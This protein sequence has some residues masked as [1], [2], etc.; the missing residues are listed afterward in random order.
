MTKS[1]VIATPNANLGNGF[2]THL[3]KHGYQV[4]EIATYVEML[5]E[6]LELLQEEGTKIDSIILTSD[7]AQKLKDKRLEYLTDVL[8]TIRKSQNV[9][10]IIYANEQEG[11]PFLGEVVRMGIYNIFVKKSHS[12]SIHISELIG[13]IENPLSFADA[14]HFL[15]VDTSIK[16]DKKTEKPPNK[17]EIIKEQTEVVPNDKERKEKQEKLLVNTIKHLSKLSQKEIRTQYRAFA[18]KA[19]VVT[20]MKGGIGKTDVSINLA[21]ALKEH[22]NVNRICVVDFDFPYGGIAAALN[23]TRS[24]D[25]GDWLLKETD[26]ITEVGVKSKVVQHANIDF[27]PMSLR[28]KDGLKFQELHA[29]LLID[30][31]KRYYDIVIIDTSGFS[32]PALVALERASEIILITSHDIVSISTCIAYKEDLINMYG[33]DYEKVSLFINQVP[34]NEDITKETI[35]SMFEDHEENS[36]PVIGFAPY[37]D[38][39][40]QYRN[41]GDFIYIEKPNHTFSKG[42][43][44]ILE[45]LEIIPTTSIKKRQSEN[46]ESRI[47]SLISKIK[48]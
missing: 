18:S 48:G 13:R 21:A 6:T 25:L 12:D 44:M 1:I 38:V 20:S 5:I 14:S 15:E 9:N 3:E 16:W 35:A 4:K 30:I 36:I 22:T 43:D 10:I 17:I 39:V 34:K 32:K 24:R 19:I 33:I 7:I 41:R 42:I 31:L 29:E 11:H 27:I 23:L 2:K 28:L 45:S 47:S 26:K 46:K 40:R 37:D 8:F